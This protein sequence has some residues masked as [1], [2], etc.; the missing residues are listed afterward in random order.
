MMGQCCRLQPF[1]EIPHHAPA[2]PQVRDLRRLIEFY[3][4]WQHRVFPHGTF[5][6][7]QNTLEKLSSKGEMRVSGGRRRDD[8]GGARPRRT[9]QLLWCVVRV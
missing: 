6:A 2:C 7:F 3:Q 1:A 5:D 4:R 8:V 9:G